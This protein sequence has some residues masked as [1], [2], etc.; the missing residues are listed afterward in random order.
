MTLRRI[1]C[2]TALGLLS[3][4]TAP[5]HG[6]TVPLTPFKA[7]ANTRPLIAENRWQPYSANV[8]ACG[9][10]D[11]LAFIQ[12]RF[13][14]REAGY[15]DSSVRIVDFTQPYEIA[16]RP[17]GPSFVPRRFCSV[18]GLFSD[19]HPRKIFYSVDEDMGLFGFGWGVT[20]CPDGLDRNLT[21]AP[22]C[23]MARP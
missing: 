22:D 2:L 23:K 10:P 19:N 20:W 4:C 3:A 6:I 16:F 1:L 12:S 21:Y 5:M 17:W 13:A 9:S 11:V 15:W 8:P 18:T 7:D 14:T